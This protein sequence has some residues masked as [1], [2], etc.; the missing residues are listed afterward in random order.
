VPGA[1]PM[2]GDSAEADGFVVVADTRRR[3]TRAEKQ[4][5]VAE[6]GPGKASVSATARK[7]NISANLLFRWRSDLEVGRR[8]PRARPE[9][10]PI[11]LPAPP[12]ASAAEGAPCGRSGVIEIELVGG[13]RVRIDGAVDAATLRRVIEV[14]EGR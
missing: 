5:I 13:R 11:A 14:L 12:V 1:V 9:F 4:A 2:S 10:M 6:C 8:K 3:W 7:H